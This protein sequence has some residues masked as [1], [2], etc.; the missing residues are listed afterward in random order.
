MATKHSKK[1]AYR[2]GLQP[3]KA[4]NSLEMWLREVT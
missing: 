1:V 3:M 2:E 4:H